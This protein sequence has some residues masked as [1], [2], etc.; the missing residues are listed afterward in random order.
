MGGA[1][2]GDLADLQIKA[3]RKTGREGVFAWVDDASTRNGSSIGGRGG[4][5]TA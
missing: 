4:P 3:G 5:E 1:R 2:G